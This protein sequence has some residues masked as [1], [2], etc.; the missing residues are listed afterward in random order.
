M[1]KKTT[2]QKCHCCPQCVEEPSSKSHWEISRRNFIAMGGVLMG[3]LTLSSLWNSVL[4]AETKTDEPFWMPKPRMPLIVKPIL[5]HDLP[6]RQEKTSWRNWGGVDSPEAAEEEVRRIR[7]ELT[8]IQ[9]KADYPV[10]FLDI[11]KTVSYSMT[12]S[13]C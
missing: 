2:N 9:Q 1:V 7:A 4:A 12:C 5:L 6:Q 3:G 8:S 11:I 10:E 13:A